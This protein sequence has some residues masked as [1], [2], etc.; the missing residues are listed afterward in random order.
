MRFSVTGL[1]LLFYVVDTYAYVTAG[2]SFHLAISNISSSHRTDPSRHA[3]RAHHY[4]TRLRPDLHQCIIYDLDKEDARLI[5]VEYVVVKETFE[6]F[7]E[8]EKKASEAC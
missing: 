5:G 6:R 8:V 4:C 3:V 2:T 1:F 7:D